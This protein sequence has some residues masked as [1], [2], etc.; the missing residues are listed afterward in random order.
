[1]TV[2]YRGTIREETA[3]RRRDSIANLT[4][5]DSIASPSCALGNHSL[6]L[7]SWFLLES[8]DER[9]RYHPSQA[10]KTSIDR[11]RIDAK[12]PQRKY[13]IRSTPAVFEI[14]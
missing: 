10:F 2:N 7:S 3:E 5:W 1:L 11:F 14:L 6:L 4:N 8:L 13:G 12:L 9:L